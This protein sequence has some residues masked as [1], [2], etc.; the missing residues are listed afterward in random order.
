MR[1]LSSLRSLRPSP[2]LSVG[3]VERVTEVEVR[4]APGLSVRGVRG[5]EWCASSLGLFLSPSPKL[6]FG[7]VGGD[8]GGEV[9]LA[10]GLSVGGWEVACVVLRPLGSLSGC[11]RNYPL[12]T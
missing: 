8:A 6:S 11:H 9:I 1:S 12:G 10:P 4:M 3:D 7:D 2:E 5:I